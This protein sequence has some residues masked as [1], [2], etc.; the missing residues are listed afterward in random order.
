MSYPVTPW[1]VVSQAP[2]SMG[3]PREWV[4][5][6]FSRG[7]S[8]PMDPTYLSYISCIGRWVLYHYCHLGSPPNGWQILSPILSFLVTF[9]IVF[10]DA[11]EF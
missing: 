8:Q 10:S 3:F 4:A 2:L 9:L 5:I 7:S 11:E 6:S 1:T